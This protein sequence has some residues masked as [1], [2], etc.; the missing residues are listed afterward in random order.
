MAYDKPITL[1]TFTRNI[2]AIQAGI[3]Q[4]LC[5]HG[6]GNRMKSTSI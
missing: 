5:F 1:I 6:P 2:L 3:N 4:A